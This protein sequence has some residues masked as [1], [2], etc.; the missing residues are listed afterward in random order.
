MLSFVVRA[1]VADVLTDADLLELFRA[2]ESARVERKESLADSARVKQAICALANDL[3]DLRLPGVIFVGQRDD[4]TC[5]GLRVDDDLL[6]RLTGFRSDGSILPFPSMR[7]RKVTLDGCE[8]AVVEVD[9]SDNP[10]VKFDGRIWVRA[11]PSRARATPQEEHRLMEKRRWGNLPFDS[12]PVPTA[13]LADLDL[14][15]FQNE[16]LPSAVPAETLAEN[17]RT[18]EHQLRAL[19]LIDG[20]GIPTAT[21]ILALGI[22]PRRFFPGAYIQFLRVDGPLLTDTL[23]DQRE[24]GGTL[25]D[26]LREA[27]ALIRL[28]IRRPAVVGG[29]V[30]IENPDYPEDALRQLVRNAVMHRTYESSNAPVRITWFSDRIEIQNPGGP[31]G[32]V[33]RATLGQPGVTDYRNPTVAEALKVLGFVERFG[34]GI[35]IAQRTLAANGNPPPVFAPEEAH[36]LVT[37][38]PRP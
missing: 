4:R 21:A 35:P 10:P 27:D 26:Q 37:V 6:L 14:A 28:N 12:R 34:L 32:Q 11:G 19:H 1:F 24:L 23:V 8:V 38:R 18:R 31:Y 20:N 9:P 16:Y 17:G 15:R 33:T 36:V 3:P 2:E 22:E 29:A 30:R 7:V 13:T 5:A 25:S